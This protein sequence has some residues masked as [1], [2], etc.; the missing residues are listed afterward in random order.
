MEALRLAVTMGDLE[1]AEVILRKQLERTPGDTGLRYRLADVLRLRLKLSEARQLYLALNRENPRVVVPYLALSDMARV[2]KQKAAAWSYLAQG[3]AVNQTGADS[4]PNLVAL[5]QRYRDWDDKE[6]AEKTLRL[7]LKIA[8][9][10]PQILLPLAALCKDTRRTAESRQILTE[11]LQRD[12]G[13][14]DAKRQLASMLADNP[15]G[16]DDVALAGRQLV[17]I[18]KDGKPLADDYMT[19]GKLA[20]HEHDWAEAA[21]AYV[22]ALALEPERPA[23]RYRLAQIYSRLGKTDYAREETARYTRLREEQEHRSQLASVRSGAPFSPAT[24]LAEA[25]FAEKTQDYR[26]AVIAYGQAA[27]LA[28]Q[29]VKIRRGRAKFYAFLGWPP[30]AS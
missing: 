7:A 14:L 3:V 18:F 26:V 16:P 17:D 24:H 15:G 22:N 19:A 9:N 10:T 5:A 6:S 20:E 12:P 8:P 2:E 21:Q 30:P 28:P 1:R 13:N 25:Q 29:D 4:V 27:R 11:I 23:A